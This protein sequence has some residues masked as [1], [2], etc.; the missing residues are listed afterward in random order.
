[1]MEFI[2]KYKKKLIIASV[3]VGIVL[4]LGGFYAGY[5]IYEKFEE[6]D[7]ISRVIKIKLNKIR[8]T[9]AD[10][11]GAFG[12]VITILEGHERIIKKLEKKVRKWR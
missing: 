2:E 6:V 9:Q 1:M 11:V 12:K 4:Q 10:I 8:K 3:S 5:K 7:K